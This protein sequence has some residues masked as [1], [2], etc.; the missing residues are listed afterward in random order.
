[1]D[2]RL[3]NIIREPLYSTEPIRDWEAK[4]AFL[5][6]QLALEA[7][8]ASVAGFFEEYRGRKERN[9]LVSEAK[10]A[11]IE[12]LLDLLSELMSKERDW[13]N[14]AK[15]IYFTQAFATATEPQRKVRTYAQ[16][17]IMS[18]VLKE[19]EL[20]TQLLAAFLNVGYLDTGR[21]LTQ[22]QFG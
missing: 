9:Y 10:F 20:W 11:D 12:R 1:M 17:Y 18:T 13:S 16:K 15:T 5:Q 7:G 6:S 2:P 22:A 19:P 14:L 8:R 3:I 21:T 4:S